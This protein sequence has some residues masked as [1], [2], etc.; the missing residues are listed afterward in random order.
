MRFLILFLH[1]WKCQYTLLRHNVYMRVIMC[2]CVT[3][4]FDS[5]KIHAVLLKWK[6]KQQQ[7]NQEEEEEAS[8][9]RSWKRKHTKRE[10]R[11]NL[12]SISHALHAM[13]SSMRIMDVHFTLNNGLF[14]AS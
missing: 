1:K 2:A 9:P 14:F 8:Q 7:P 3:N 6:K 10:K 4:K 12:F 11:H 5:T 13:G